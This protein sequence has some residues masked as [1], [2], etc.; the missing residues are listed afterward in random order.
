MKRL[1]ITIV[2]ML[3]ILSSVGFL[4]AEDNWPHWRG[5]HHNGL[6]HAKNLPMNWSTTGNVVWKTPLPSWSAATPIIWGDRIFIT[7]PSRSK[8]KPEPEQKQAEEPSQT[9]RRRR[10]RSALDPGG[11]KLLLFCIAKK[12]G[13]ILWRRELDNKNQ[14]HRKQN[15]ATPSPVTDGRLVWVVTGTGKI[16]AFNMNG[17]PVWIKLVCFKPLRLQEYLVSIVMREFY[18]LI[19]Q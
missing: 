6:S 3:A 7:S 10:R 2:L 13:K 17:K 19:F 14:I 5:P 18:Y 11:P 8:P 9:E 15:D 1:V 4:H 16:A 12:D